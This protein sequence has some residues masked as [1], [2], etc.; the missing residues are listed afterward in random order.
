MASLTLDELFEKTSKPGPLLDP[1]KD[2][3]RGSSSALEASPA[4]LVLLERHNEL[5]ARATIAL[6]QIAGFVLDL[7]REKEE[8]LAREVARVERMMKEQEEAKAEAKLDELTRPTQGEVIQMVKS[9][10]I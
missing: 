8:H 1:E 6:E 9:E 5:F 7:K 10:G 4:L 2:K 3:P